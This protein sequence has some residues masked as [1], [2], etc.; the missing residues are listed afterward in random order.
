MPKLLGTLLDLDRCPHCS[1]DR[2]TLA[3]TGA[4]HETTDFGGENKRFWRCYRCARCG[5]IITAAERAMEQG[6]IEIYPA[7]LDVDASVPER[8]RTF[9]AQAINRLSSPAGAVMLAAS[10]V[11]AMLK[12]KGL[13]D[14]SLYT[15]IDKAALTTSDLGMPLK[16][17]KRCDR[18]RTAK[19]AQRRGLR[20]ADACQT[21]Q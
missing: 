9:L 15:R 13:P 2:P 8:A 4:Q 19:Q 3:F 5:G 11:D 16:S 10:A 17:P 12:A 20:E 7:G 21:E 1:V 14:G 6:I 18:R